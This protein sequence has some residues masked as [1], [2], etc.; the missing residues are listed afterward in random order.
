ML[1][2][3][4]RAGVSGAALADL[5]AAIDRGLPGLRGHAAGRP[6]TPG[7]LLA[8]RWLRHPCDYQGLLRHVSDTR[9]LPGRSRCVQLRQPVFKQALSLPFNLR[10]RAVP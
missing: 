8:S 4:L 7:R 1:A 9:A 3:G 10:V 2:A 6:L 5:A